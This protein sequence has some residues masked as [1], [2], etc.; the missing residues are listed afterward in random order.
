[1]CN[2][3]YNQKLR[4]LQLIIRNN[5]KIKYLLWLS[6]ACGLKKLGC[7]YVLAIKVV[8][9]ISFNYISV[10]PSTMYVEVSP[11]KCHQSNF[12]FKIRRKYAS[13]L[14]GRQ[15]RLLGMHRPRIY[16]QESQS[17][18]PLGPLVHTMADYEC[19][20]A[21]GCWSACTNFPLTRKGFLLFAENILCLVILICFHAST[22]GYSLSVTEM[23]F[24]AIFFVVYMC[25]L[26]TKIQ[27][28]SWPWSD[29]LWTLVAIILYLITSIVDYGA[30]WERK[31]LQNH[32]GRYCPYAP[33]D[34]LI[35]MP[36][37]PS[38]SLT[39]QLRICL[40]CRRPW[41]D[42]W[43]RKILWRRDRLPTPV[44]LGFPCG[45]AGKE[46]ACNAGDLGLIPGLGR[47]LEKGKATHSSILA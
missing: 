34:S 5:D 30:C 40:Q 1:M 46:S 42:S 39:A 19:V 35:M 15:A 28:I 20:W 3:P 23:T 8:I 24:A 13:W 37:L 6:D 41:F 7:L 36:T 22:S 33:H 26:P 31:Q 4:F 2:W 18:M 21:P 17:S 32:S 45:S 25:D 27:I 11:L 9:S 44:F 16:K 10:S 14:D 29:F 38:P 43:V 12:M 47:S